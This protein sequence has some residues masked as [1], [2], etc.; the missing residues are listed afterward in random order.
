MF[1]FVPITTTLL[2]MIPGA[3]SVA[4]P[5]AASQ[6]A[7]WRLAT[8]ALGVAVINGVKIEKLPLLCE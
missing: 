8:V 3:A 7:A 6:A 2:G 5:V 1:E 4:D